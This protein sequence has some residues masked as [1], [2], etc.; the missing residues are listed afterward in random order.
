V[1]GGSH[2]AVPGEIIG[3]QKAVQDAL[4]GIWIAVR[5][6]QGG[7]ELSQPAVPCLVLEE[8][9][10]TIEEGD[11]SL[12]GR[13]QIDSATDPKQLRMMTP[14]GQVGMNMSF[15]LEAG[16]LTLC[17]DPT[18][19]APAPKK[20][21]TVEGDEQFLVVLAP[22]LVRRFEGCEKARGIQNTVHGVALSADGR[23]ALA[24]G[25]AGKLI[26]WDAKSGGV[27]RRL[28]GRQGWIRSLAISPD[29][30]R[31]LSGGFDRTVRLW[32]VESG[33]QL[34]RFE[35]ES[36]IFGLAFSHDGRLAAAAIDIEEAGR[37][38]GPVCV[39]DLETGKQIHHIDAHRFA[40]SSV[41]FSPDGQQILSGGYD[42]TMR[43]W[44]VETGEEIRHFPG[45]RDWVWTVVFSPD[46]RFALSAGGGLWRDGERLPGDDFVIR[47]WDLALATGK[48][49]DDA[50]RAAPK[51]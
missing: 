15:G 10:F 50:P 26:V 18:P 3:K 5:C 38:L 13:Y 23:L 4:Q 48:E 39:W 30:Q 9:R 25:R 6:E 40:A 31:A 51:E 21:E 45:H 1:T 44:D 41:A 12:K 27:L 36:W 22:V 11:R 16:K 43:L 24:G 17:F 32:D 33:K 37:N 7:E 49:I 46:G 8:D 42:W 20:L 29:G 34:R 35:T 2:A 28:E 14:G 47:M 19:N